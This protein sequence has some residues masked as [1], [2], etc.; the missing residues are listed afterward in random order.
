MQAFVVL[1]MQLCMKS[2]KKD[3]RLWFVYQLVGFALW[4]WHTFHS[5]FLLNDFNCVFTQI[6]TSSSLG[7]WVLVR[8]SFTC[9]ALAYVSKEGCTY[10][11]ANLSL[12]M[13]IEFS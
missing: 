9:I 13:I 6:S 11:Q 12:A 8:P 1:M 7:F 5:N 3:T 4:Y 10:R 2:K